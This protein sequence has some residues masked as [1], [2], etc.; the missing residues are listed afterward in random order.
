MALLAG[1]TGVGQWRYDL[2]E[3]FVFD[4]AML[5]LLGAHTTPPPAA[6]WLMEM[7]LPSAQREALELALITADEQLEVSLHWQGLDG[8]TRRVIWMGTVERDARRTVIRG[9][10]LCIDVTVQHQL[11]EAQRLPATTQAEPDLRALVS[12][13]SQE[14]RSPLNAMLGFVQ[15]LRRSNDPDRAH[16]FD[17]Y[18]GQV[19]Q[20]GWHMLE[21]V[22]DVMDLSRLEAG[23]TPVD[24]ETVPLVDLM[25]ELLPLI[26][27]LAS[28][29]HLSLIHI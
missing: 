16:Q 22:N 15:L 1:A 21:M 8:V 24:I 2:Q 5:R 7:C 20:A 13:I 26:E 3:G 10:G 11:H 12:R 29:Q 6:A 23:A 25:G 17:D 14:L 18:L 27:Q 9:E 4:D 28:V 19:E